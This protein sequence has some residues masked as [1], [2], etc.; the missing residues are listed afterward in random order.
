MIT[1]SKMTNDSLNNEL[2]NISFCQLKMEDENSATNNLDLIGNANLNSYKNNFV[3][4]LAQQRLVHDRQLNDAN[5]KIEKNEEYIISLSK[6]LIEIKLNEVTLKQEIA[7]KFNEKKYLTLAYENSQ[8]ELNIL[9]TRRKEETNS[10]QKQINEF[11]KKISDKD[12]IIEKYQKEFAINNE[13]VESL[14][15]NIVEYKNQYENNSIL[16]I[17]KNRITK[18]K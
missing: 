16:G 2:S 13:L 17:I 1:L 4:E 7:E 18:K 15:N 12:S 9:E 8:K 11:V 10:M 14:Q 5:E 3:T 6:E